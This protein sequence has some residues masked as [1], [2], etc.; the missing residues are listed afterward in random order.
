MNSLTKKKVAILYYIAMR[1]DDGFPLKNAIASAKIA[2]SETKPYI[3]T[4]L[5]RAD[6]FL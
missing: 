5:Q 3:K 1:L 6:N 4:L 2:F